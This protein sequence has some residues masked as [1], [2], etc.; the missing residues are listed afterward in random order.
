MSTLEQQESQVSVPEKQAYDCKYPEEVR[1]PQ[2]EVWDPVAKD[3]VNKPGAYLIFNLAF[4][5]AVLWDNLKEKKYRNQFT[6]G[7]EQG[8]WKVHSGIKSQ[9]GNRSFKPDDI[10]TE[11]V[12]QVL[13]GSTVEGDPSLEDFVKNRLNPDGDSQYSEPLLF[14]SS[15]DE[16]L[17]NRTK[18]TDI[19]EKKPRGE[20]KKVD[21]PDFRIEW[22]DLWLFP[23]GSG[24]FSFKVLLDDES[25]GKEA[26]HHNVH[27]ITRI[28][29]LIRTL[30][31]H[32]A[33]TKVIR[34]NAETEESH[35]ES[36]GQFWPSLFKELLGFDSKENGGH[37]HLLMSHLLFKY[38]CYTEGTKVNPLDYTDQY[39][40]YCKVLV[41]AQVQGLSGDKD[42]R[43]KWN[44]PINDLSHDLEKIKEGCG[45]DKNLYQSALIAGYATPKDMVPFELATVSNHGSSVGW[46]DDPGWE[47]NREYIRVLLDENLIEVWENWS[48]LALRDT[49]VYVS[50]SPKVP[51][52]DQAESRYYPLYIYT[53][54]LRYQLDKLSDEIVDYGMSDVRNGIRILD[55]FQ[56]F[57]NHYWFQ[58]A[59]RDFVG[60]EVFSRMKIGMM[61]NDLY[62]AVS[63]EVAEV[64]QH[65]QQRWERSIKRWGMLL[66][67]FT[68]PVKTFWDEYLYPKGQ[69]N[70]PELWRHVSTHMQSDNWPIYLAI[71]V[72]IFGCIWFVYKWC[73]RNKELVNPIWLKWSGI[74]IRPFRRLILALR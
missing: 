35:N 15:H 65:L 68:W 49:L 38:R 60:V 28:T 5:H 67:I 2:Y 1:F 32:E 20:Y 16:W 42:F 27:H 25:T 70:W 3:M 43:L 19:Q 54:H 50:Y 11:S 46:K 53:Y 58:E 34:T 69:E 26:N 36:E 47:Y 6:K 62:D 39:S 10:I 56:Q 57:R 17:S 59:T 74:I 73:N 64:S 21:V 9:K 30:R 51:I 7:L 12:G 40:R 37:S 14:T 18:F 33:G 13:L 31:D 44:K 48:A 41:A 4:E 8:K 63:S 29:T 22:I 72:A 52:M 55:N 24:M 45:V 71:V 61:A 23:D 66:V